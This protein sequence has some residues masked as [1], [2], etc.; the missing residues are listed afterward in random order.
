MAL[1]ALLVMGAGAAT[2]DPTYDAYAV[3]GP[4]GDLPF[5]ISA[6]DILNGMFG[7]VEAGG[8]HAATPPPGE[9]DLTDGV[10]GSGVE[11]VLADYLNPSLQIRYDFENPVNITD[12][13]VFS[14][15]YTP[16]SYNSR[17]YQNYDVEYVLAGDPTTYT[18]LEYVRCTQYGA[19]NGSTEFVGATLTH[20]YDDTEEFVL[21]NVVELRFRFYCVGQTTGGFWD[22]WD[23]D[24]PED[25]DGNPAAFEASIIK[26]IDVFGEPAGIPG[27]VDGDGD[28][29]L[30]DLALLLSA[31]GACE[32]DPNY[33]P[34]ADIDNSGCVDLTDLAALLSNYGFGT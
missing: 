26:E 16:P 17:A 20:I 30:N 24:H 10:E 9:E 27:D 28:V 11:A 3:D 5:A 15:N 33:N 8:F 21:Q 18:L 23:A 34:A 29:D 14:A 32:G 6:D 1:G 7:A 22:P 25:V 2:A 4:V 12:I 13:R 31:Y 19:W